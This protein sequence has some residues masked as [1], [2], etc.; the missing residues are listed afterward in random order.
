MCITMLLLACGNKEKSTETTNPK[1]QEIVAKQENNVEE[2]AD[3]L[4]E[5]GHYQSQNGTDIYCIYNSQSSADFDTSERLSEE[6]I[7]A[8][9]ADMRISSE[10]CLSFIDKD[11]SFTYA[12]VLEGEIHSVSQTTEEAKID[13]MQLEE[14]VRQEQIERERQEKIEQAERERQAKKEQAERE[15]QAKIAEEEEEFRHYEKNF[16]DYLN[17]VKIGTTMAEFNVAVYKM[18]DSGNEY[19]ILYSRF[20]S[21][22]NKLKERLIGKQKK[23]FPIIRERYASYFRN[24]FLSYGF[25]DIK[26]VVFGTTLT[27][28]HD[29]FYEAQVRSAVYESM[30]NDMKNYRFKKLILKSS[31]GQ[32]IKQYTLKSKNDTDL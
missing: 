7:K 19:K 25:S 32:V 26:F 10:K 16:N 17:S 11:A 18:S 30:A 14:K 9:I 24:S 29:S 8:F 6:E 15:R 20:G 21:K 3:R 5:G 27:I 1:L 12:R 13:Q 23:F 4:E 22:A 2:Y 28:L 31:N